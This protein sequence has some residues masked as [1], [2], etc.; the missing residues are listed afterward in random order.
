MFAVIGLALGFRTRS[1]HE[2]FLIFASIALALMAARRLNNAFVAWTD[3]IDLPPYGW[4]ASVM[5][6]PTLAVWTIAWNHW[7][8]RPRRSIDLLAVVLAVA[9]ITGAVMHWT[10]VTTGSRL[11]S[12]ALLV[13]IGLRIARGGPMRTLAPV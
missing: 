5:S 8:L 7:C 3:L 12:L 6:V 1:S 4:L 2:S 9:G 10:S 13:V 11:G